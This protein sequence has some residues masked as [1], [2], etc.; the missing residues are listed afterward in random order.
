MKVRVGR[1]TGANVVFNPTKRQY[2]DKEKPDLFSGKTELL[3]T[4]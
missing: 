4:V 3:Y 1:N 2:C